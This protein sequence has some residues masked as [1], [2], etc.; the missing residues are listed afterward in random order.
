MLSS[1]CHCKENDETIWFPGRTHTPRTYWNP[2]A[3]TPDFMNNIITGD[4]PWEYGYDPELVI[5]LTLKIRREHLTLSHSNAA[6]HQLT[7]LTGEK[8]SQMRMKGRGRPIQ[9][10]F[11]EIHQVF[12]TKK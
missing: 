3:V 5:F 7:L 10:C 6:C 8:N 12:T 1:D 4:E 9:T 2:Q 11:I